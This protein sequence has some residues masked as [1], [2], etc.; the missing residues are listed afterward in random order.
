LLKAN[1]TSKFHEKEFGTKTVDG[2]FSPAPDCSLFVWL[3]AD[4]WC[5]F[6]LKKNN[7]GWLLVAGLF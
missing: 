4:S 6:L 7:V 1:Y 2:A 3:V 5:W